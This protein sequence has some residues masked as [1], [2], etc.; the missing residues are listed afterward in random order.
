MQYSWLPQERREVIVRE[1]PPL[2]ISSKRFARIQANAS[3]A[4]QQERQYRLQ[5]RGQAEEQLRAGGEE[6]LRQ[7]GGRKLCIT[8]AEEC[9]RE[10]E[11]LREQELEAKRLAEEESAASRR[12]AQSRQKERIAAAQQLLEQ[13]RPVPR[14]LQCVRL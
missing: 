2:V 3:Q 10:L 6:L 14:E 11:Q 5:L 12:E 7:F 9:R 4:A 8:K 13:L 1:K